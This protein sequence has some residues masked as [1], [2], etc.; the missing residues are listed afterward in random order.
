MKN[1][2]KEGTNYIFNKQQMQ[3]KSENHKLWYRLPVSRSTIPLIDSYKMQFDFID[4]DAYMCT[5]SV[6]LY[7]DRNINM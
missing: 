2:R 1:K 7:G 4:S 6:C 3:K 5:V